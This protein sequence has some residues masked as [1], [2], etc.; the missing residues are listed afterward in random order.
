MNQ[1]QHRVVHIHPPSILLHEFRLIKVLQW[2]GM[3][4]YV[5]CFLTIMDYI[6]QLFDCSWVN[7]RTAPMH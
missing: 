3:V 1:I 7:F 4:V 5:V 2:T 6:V